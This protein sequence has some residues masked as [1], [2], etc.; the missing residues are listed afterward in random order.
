[1]KNLSHIR[2]TN[3]S[4]FYYGSP[5]YPEHWDAG[6]RE[7]DAEW[8]QAA[9]WNCVRMAEF[10]WDHIEAL[11]GQFDYSL[12]DETIARL[13]ERS[14]FTILCTPTAT[15]PRWLSDRHPDMM[16]VN[17]Q[18][19]I[20]QHGSRQHPCQNNL[21][22]RAHSRRITRAM[23]S[24]YRD[25]PY[26]VGWQ[27]DNEINCHFAECHCE[28][29]QETF[30]EFLQLKYKDDIHALNHSWGTAFWSQTVG[31]FR[32]IITPRE[33]KPTY[34]NPGQ[35]LDYLRFIAWTAAE[36]QGEQVAILREQPR[37]FITHNG[38]MQH[39]D[40]R[41][42]FTQEL[43]F[44]G[45]DDYPMFNKDHTTRPAT[46]AFALDSAR[47]W[48]GNFMV[49]EQQS[50][51]G[52][53]APYFHDNPEPGEMRRMAYESIAHGADSLLFFRWRTCR[54]GAEEYWCGILDHDNIRRRRY[55]EASQLGEELRRIGPAVLGTHIRVEAAVAS[56]S[57]DVT[58]AH[59]TLP[60]GLPDPRAVAAEVHRHFWE[61][62]WAAGCI[63]P[64]DDLSGV[65][66]YVLPHWT[67][68]DPAWV[69][70]LED[71]VRGGG[72]LV[73]GARTATKDLNNNVVAE[74]LP[75]VLRDLAGVSV[76]EYSKQNAPDQ[77]PYFL[78]IE[79][80]E[81][82]SRHWYEALRPVG[83]TQ[84]LATWKSRHLTGQPAISLRRL[85]QGAVLYV[86]TY[87][88][89]ELLETL[90][91][92]LERLGRIH[93]LWPAPRGVSVVLR[94]GVNRKIWFF[95]NVSDDNQVLEKLPVGVDLVRGNQAPS[96]IELAPNEVIVIEENK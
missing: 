16:R 28:S 37:W 36:F 60:F 78:E 6:T 29:C 43:D 44:L 18:G 34:P 10:A 7:H 59:Q 67:V 5:Y 95:I 68:F 73:I 86:G 13:G 69:N 72:V 4:R 76:E 81:V 53:Q 1:M 83:D 93:P 89:S 94:E 15:P 22:F 88:T 92:I 84:V 49:P 47:A 48:S 70:P 38:I 55:A 52:G 27:T 56:A 61:K 39:V 42:K 79:G 35:Q 87:F 51:P 40:Y 74:T 12:F 46:N 25:N 64:E 26:V 77:R 2:P 90:L 41:G 80:K 21:F 96:S 32:E 58:D 82:Q 33:N 31:S 75:G 20:M 50:G 9:G 11:E 85:G 17:A 66:L 8:M 57:L 23:A 54:F 30:R 14:I 63:H 19:V 3:L 65:K 24:H 62:G 91:P 71:Y 45:F